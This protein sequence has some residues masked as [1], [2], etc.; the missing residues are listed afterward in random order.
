MNPLTS[1]DLQLPKED[2]SLDGRRHHDDLHVNLFYNRHVQE[3][4][5]PLSRASD[6][7]IQEQGT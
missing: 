1:I 5:T 3:Q 4:A 7:T 2:I 6:A